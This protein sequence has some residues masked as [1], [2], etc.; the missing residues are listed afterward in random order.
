MCLSW[1]SESFT[2]DVRFRGRHT[3]SW[4]EYGQVLSLHGRCKQGTFCAH[5]V[6]RRV[7]L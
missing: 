3:I 7:I 2:L 4:V 1:R 6:P 5:V